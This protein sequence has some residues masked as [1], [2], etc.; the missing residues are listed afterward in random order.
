MI[1]GDGGSTSCCTADE[2]G[3]M[4]ATF[5]CSRYVQVGDSDITN[6]GE[7]GCRIVIATIDIDI[8]RVAVTV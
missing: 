5:D 4:Y 8:D 3:R 2:S 1:K 6:L 7:E